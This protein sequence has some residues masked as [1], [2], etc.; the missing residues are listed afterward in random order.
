MVDGPEGMGFQSTYGPSC[1]ED[2][3]IRMDFSVRTNRPLSWK[4]GVGAEAHWQ[5]SRIL[6]DKAPF[7]QLPRSD[8]GAP[9]AILFPKRP[10]DPC[11]FKLNKTNR[12]G[13]LAPF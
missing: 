1:R 6:A 13:P 10:V 8:Q 7:P 2:S 4:P 9:T 12:L 5:L 3:D 11:Y